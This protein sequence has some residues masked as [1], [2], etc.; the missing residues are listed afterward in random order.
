VVR[1]G[2]G[3]GCHLWATVRI[4]RCQC[5][6]PGLCSEYQMALAKSIP[7]SNQ[8]C[9]S[10]SVDEI[11]F[12][13][14]CLGWVMQSKRIFSEILVP[15][16]SLTQKSVFLFFPARTFVTFF[17]NNESVSPCSNTGKLWS[18]DNPC[19]VKAI[20]R[21]WYNV[22]EFRLLSSADR[23]Y[24]AYIISGCISLFHKVFV[25]RCVFLVI[26]SGCVQS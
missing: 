7:V 20:S 9:F 15:V 17:F 18:F 22:S 12:L 21:L 4:A 11:R 14:G 2:L 26:F 8:C 1:A 5:L 23:A 6:L 24:I 19:N 25:S 16:S 13:S 10:S 3:E